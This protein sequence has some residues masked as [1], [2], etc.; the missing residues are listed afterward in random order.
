MT[1]TAAILPTDAAWNRSPAG[2][3]AA[4]PRDV[5]D[6]LLT[7]GT[8]I[9]AAARKSIVPERQ[10]ELGQ[11]FTPMWVAELMASMVPAV[12]GPTRVLDPGAGA[13]TLFTAYAARALGQKRPPT[14]LSLTAF[15]V[16]A[17]LRPFLERSARAVREAC[18]S[19]SVA[20]DVTLRMD[21]FARRTSRD[22]L[23]HLFSEP[24]TYDVAI[25]NPPYGKL[26]SNS[27]LRARLDA[28]GIA[29]PNLYAAFLGLALRV[30]RPGGSVVAIVPRS[31]CNGTYFRRFRRYLL[32]CAGVTRFHLFARRDRAFGEDAVLQ[33]NVVLGLRRGVE[34][35]ST[36]TLSFSNGAQGD[37]AWSWTASVDDVVRRGDAD[38]FVHL[39]DGEWSVGLSRAMDS[40]PSTL[41]ELG[42]GVSTGPVVSFRMRRW[43]A[44]PTSN[45]SVAPLLHPANLH[46]LSVRWPVA[47]KKP[48]A[49]SRAPETEQV[50]IPNGWYVATRRFSSK[51]EKQRVVASAIDP[52]RLPGSRI[53]LE[54]HLNYFHAAGEPLQRDLAVGLATY[55]NSTF[56]DRYF[57][58]FSGHTQV[59]ATDLRKLRYPRAASL[60]TLGASLNAV[61]AGTAA[62]LSLRRYCKELRHMPDTDAVKARIDEGLTV[63]RDLGMPRE[64]LNERSA[65]TLLALVGVTPAA[66]WESASAPLMG[67]TPIM[68][69]VEAHYGRRYAPNTRETF[70]RFTIHQFLD[71]GLVVANPDN[72]QR[73]VNSPRYCYRIDLAALA[74][75]RAFGSDGWKDAL[76][77]YLR[78]ELEPPPAAWSA[79]KPRASSSP[80]MPARPSHSAAT[81]A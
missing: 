81:L 48:Q 45:D 2:S 30:V 10:R 1:G 8:L 64:Q 18:A 55:L 22:A 77:D 66:A 24:E 16:D 32:D 34:R 65:L 29:A 12:Q 3:A 11:Y 4:R 7:H 52:E 56:V 28:L 75:L 49:L 46:G 41:A 17:T 50:L 13:G 78:P 76:A 72:P 33:E 40:L 80:A 20:C 9:Q 69:W 79:R 5:A 68:E 57:R 23:G 53:A 59:N 35:P 39:P 44:R 6:R 21:D 67:G 63:L 60:T 14:A 70:R 51:E 19:R 38:C 71:A 74:L 37:P 61:L 54:N 36:V 42:V 58:Q 43:L 31:F 73:P 25:L 27:D 62:D 15:E 47:G 26:S